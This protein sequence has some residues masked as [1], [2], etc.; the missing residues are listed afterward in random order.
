[1]G[2]EGVVRIHVPFS[3]TDLSSIEKCLGSFSTNPTNF[4]K[5]FQYLVQAYDLT[6]HDLHI[7]LTFTMTLDERTMSRLQ[8]GL[9]QT[10]PTPPIPSCQ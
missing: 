5:E 1:M 3:L 4:I 6:W 7:I 9:M 2:A 10:K 8:L